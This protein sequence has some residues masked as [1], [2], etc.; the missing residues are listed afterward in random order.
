M[1]ESIRQIESRLHRASKPA[2][3]LAVKLAETDTIFTSCESP[4]N[5]NSAKTTDY[6]EDKPP[7][8]DASTGNRTA[9]GKWA[10]VNIQSD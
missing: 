8:K 3:H 4:C 7:L 10:P 2:N 6:H 9:G 5:M 1:N